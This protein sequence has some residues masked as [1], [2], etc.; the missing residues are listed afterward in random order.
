MALLMLILQV[1][2]FLRRPQFTWYAW[3]AAISFSAFLYSVAIFFEYNT[4]EGPIN[5]FSGLMEFTAIIFLVHAL[6]GFTFSYLGI[7]SKRYHPVAGVCHGLILILL[8]T[9]PYIVTESFTTRDFI[10]L[11]TPYL[12]PALGP[13]GPLFVLYAAIACVIAMIIWIK[14]RKTD[15]KHRGILLVG[16]GVWLLLGIHDGLAAMGVPTLQYFMEYG[17]LGFAMVVLWVVFDTYLEIAAEEKYRVITEFA[18]DCILVVQDEKMVFAN[19]ACSSLIGRPLTD[20]RPKHFL[21]IMM[22]ADRKAVLK[23]YDDL[24]KGGQVPNPQ[25]VRIQRANGEQGFV[26][27]ASSVIRYR[28]R[29]AVLAIVRD[30][31]ERKRTEEVLRESEEKFRS[32]MEAMSDS[33]Y[34]CTP[35]FRIA[36][37]NPSMIKIIGRD[38]TGERCHKALFD[39]DEQCPLCFH[40]KVQKGES[41]ETEIVLPKNNRTYNVIHSPI[42]HEDGSISKM[43]IFRDITVTK[44]LQDRLFRSERLS[45]TGQLAATIA[46]EIN[47]P[48]QGITSLLHSMERASNQDKVLSE[49]LGLVKMGFIR[50]RDTVQKLLDLNRP[51]KEM[52]QSTNIHGVIQD[53]VALLK[54]Y[55][56]KNQ[57]TC[58]LNLSQQMPHITASP[59]QLGQVFMNLISNAVEAMTGTSKSKDGRR[60]GETDERKI[61]VRSTL[62]ED[63][64]VVEVSDTGPG[65][66][67]EDMKHIFD[68]F[69]TRKKEMGMGIGLSLCHGILEDHNGSITAENSPERG[70]I[71][72]ITLPIT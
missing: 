47:S 33:V 1:L 55:L 19:P 58:I 53:T 6:Y 7:A 22:P 41:A 28:K 12:E 44:Q 20:A 8:W 37:M 5:R 35:E 69:Y 21:D 56:K 50:I 40:A 30:M 70:A 17:F 45:A 48:L 10:G 72:T 68:P 61:T 23:H 54:S 11:K 2:F 60:T 4:P 49:K 3:S 62:T 63:T 43:T 13:L 38:A 26:E 27:I 67:I 46:H 25:A 39:Q 24:L 14:D 31:T 52:K 18:N 65:I 29:P 66:S 51:G 9:T 59:Q 57:V 32:M 34:I 16:M 71:F 15:P 36:Y 42:F 64:I